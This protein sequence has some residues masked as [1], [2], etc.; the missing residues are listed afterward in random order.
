MQLGTAYL[1]S[2]LT[3]PG[4]EPVPGYRLLGRIGIGGSGEV[5]SAEGPGGFYVALKFVRLAEGL[6]DAELRTLQILRTIRHPNLLSCFGAWQAEEFLVLGMELADQT[7]WDW[8]NEAIGQGLAGIPRDELIEAMGEAAKGIDYLNEPRHPLGGQERAKILHRDV[9]P[10]NIVLVGGGVKVADFGL[11]RL[12]DQGLTTQ[13]T[14]RWTFAYAAP[15]FFRGQ[16]ADQSDQYSL[17]VTYCHLRGGR[18]PFV[19]DPEAI[20]AGHLLHPPDLSM[21]P[22]AERPAVARALAKDPPERWPHCRAF[23]DALRAGVS[24][25]AATLPALPPIALGV[26]DDRAEPPAITPEP[27]PARLVPASTSPAG[28]P[29]LRRELQAL[30]AAGVLSAVGLALWVASPS[31]HARPLH[32]A[33]AMTTAPAAEPELAPIRR[34]AFR[35]ALDPAPR[36]EEPPPPPAGEPVAPAQAVAVT[37]RSPAPTPKEEVVGPPKVVEPDATGDDPPPPDLPALMPA[38]PEPVPLPEAEGR[39]PELTAPIEATTPDRGRDDGDDPASEPSAEPADA[40]A[41]RPPTLVLDLPKSLTLEGGRH[42]SFS[43]RVARDGLAGPVRVRFDDLPRGLSIADVTVP[44]DADRA[45]ADAA[46]AADAPEAE[47]TLKVIATA[48]VARAEATLPLAVLP[49]PA[50][51]QRRQGDAH[52]G[53]GEFGQAIAHYNE[54]ILLDPE[55]AVARLLKGSA[56]YK[57]G[58]YDR[59]L[60]A[61]TEAIRLR[62]GD[63]VAYNN[64]GLAYRS[65][66]EPHKAI[67]DYNEAIRLK[68]G[69]PIARYNRGLAYSY[70]GDTTLAIA[71]FDAAIRL[72]PHYVRALR[73]RGD[74]HSRRG[75]DARARADRAAA[76]Q[77]EEGDPG[78]PSPRTFP[79]TRRASA[80][81]ASPLTATLRGGA[82]G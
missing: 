54:A 37:D 44:A 48:G 40:P 43:F 39:P 51:V 23:V 31:S 62:P 25:S 29:R 26:D 66:G 16:V 77:F 35:P 63:P 70:L 49:S 14:G 81:G 68:P 32:Q 47:A 75:D 19:G 3:R 7:L 17:A 76:D 55:D 82:E 79:A 73:A 50:V 60:L 8:F 12:A 53:R 5:W 15:E 58:D 27:A 33:A 67:A 57:A 34:L 41:S 13:G 65:R 22:A 30:A 69:D 4:G 1:G 2:P 59:A 72:N 71:D 42:A 11:A 10:Q 9:K 18:P 6:G 45:E 64:R 36:P 52:L 38:A 80:P 28:P 21:L 46:V 61:F 78:R 24:T 74:A 56:C 20:M